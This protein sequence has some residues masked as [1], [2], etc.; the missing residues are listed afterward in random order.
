MP[1]TEYRLWQ[2]YDAV[3]PLSVTAAL[4]TLIALFRADYGTVNSRR[5]YDF[6]DLRY[7]DR[8]TQAQI[9]QRILDGL[10][11]MGFKETDNE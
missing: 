11:G 5:R 10:R 7:Y 8:P 1:I 6:R 9:N 3:E 2:R 4:D